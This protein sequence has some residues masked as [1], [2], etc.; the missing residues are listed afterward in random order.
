MMITGAQGTM[1]TQQAGGMEALVAR[2]FRRAGVLV[3]RQATATN[4]QVRALSR[5]R[6][7]G[8]MRMRI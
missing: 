3:G 8:G 7:R 1:D 6:I 5:I 4:L 2:E